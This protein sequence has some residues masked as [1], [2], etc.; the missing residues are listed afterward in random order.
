MRVEPVLQVG[1]LRALVQRLHVQHVL[2]ER[3]TED[4]EE[5]EGGH[6]GHGRCVKHCT[7]VR[8]ERV[9]ECELSC[10]TRVCKNVYCVSHGGNETEILNNSVL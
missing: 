3:D 2:L 8:S 9:G 10:L 1:L 6:G 5:T 4:T 7:A